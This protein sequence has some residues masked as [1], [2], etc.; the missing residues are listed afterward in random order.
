M[1]SMLLG[2]HTVDGVLV[3]PVQYLSHSVSSF[4]LL[5]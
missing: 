1:P 3:C 4:S 2:Q 5:V